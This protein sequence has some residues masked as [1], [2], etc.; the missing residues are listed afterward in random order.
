MKYCSLIISDIP[1]EIMINLILDQDDI[2]FMF[3]ITNFIDIILLIIAFI[4]MII[5]Y[6]IDF[7]YMLKSNSKLFV[8]KSTQNSFKVH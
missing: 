1:Q 3:K 6:F 4:F 5:L 7:K 2:L 8:R